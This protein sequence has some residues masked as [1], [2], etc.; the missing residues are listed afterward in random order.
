MHTYVLYQNAAIP[1]DVT[2]IY[3][4][5]LGVTMYDVYCRELFECADGVSRNFTGRSYALHYALEELSNKMR[6]HKPV[7][8]RKN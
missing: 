3:D 7:A 5:K 6:E 1:V 4:P 2:A 8:T